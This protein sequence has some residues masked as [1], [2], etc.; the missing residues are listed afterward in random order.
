MNRNTSRQGSKF[1][2]PKKEEVKEEKELSEPII[3]QGGKKVIQA[4]QLPKIK[5]LEQQNTKDKPVD[6]IARL[7]KIALKSKKIKIIDKG[8]P[9][10]LTPVSGSGNDADLY[11]TL[12]RLPL[13]KLQALYNSINA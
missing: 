3:L 11:D 5:L 10:T 1:K 12:N 9:P 6:P 13:D 7:R 8:V 4:V 2:V